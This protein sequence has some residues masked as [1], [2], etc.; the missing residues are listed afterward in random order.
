MI[1]INLQVGKSALSALEVGG[2][3]F[4][5]INVKWILIAVVY[6]FVSESS[7]K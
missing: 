6:S 4:S 1:E 2:L 3:N 5:K 7:F